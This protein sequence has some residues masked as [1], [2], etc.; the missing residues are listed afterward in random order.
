MTEGV[1][2]SL[3]LGAELGR[4][5]SVGDPEGAPLREGVVDGS[6]DSVGD[7]EG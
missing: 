2:L 1:L 7:T 5:D 3:E 6:M 4:P